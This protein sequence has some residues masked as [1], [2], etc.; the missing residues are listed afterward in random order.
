MTTAKATAAY[1]LPRH[2]THSR[3]QLRSSLDLL[4]YISSRPRVLF[5]FRNNHNISVAT[6]RRRS[7]MRTAVL[8]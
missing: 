8:P 6:S 2:F 4:R 3:L 1:R 7:T 5:V